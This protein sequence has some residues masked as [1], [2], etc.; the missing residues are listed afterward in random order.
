MTEP[1]TMRPQLLCY[2]RRQ[3]G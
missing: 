3:L 1:N 2:C